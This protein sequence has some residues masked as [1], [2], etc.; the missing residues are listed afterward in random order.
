MS[1]SLP[2]T[3]CLAPARFTNPSLWLGSFSCHLHER[4]MHSFLR[5]AAW[6]CS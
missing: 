5:Q 2:P 4:E 3:L 1:R 6:T